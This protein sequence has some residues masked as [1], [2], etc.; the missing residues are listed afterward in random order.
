MAHDDAHRHQS[1]ARRRIGPSR[2]S[3]FIP[4]TRRALACS[5]AGSRASRPR[6]DRACCRSDR[7]TASSPARSSRRSTGA[8]HNASS[9]RVGDLVAPRTDPYSGQPEAKATPAAIAPVDF[10]MRGFALT[11]QPIALPRGHLVG[12]RRGAGWCRHTVCH[13]RSARAPGAIVAPACCRASLPNTSTRPRHLSRCGLR[14]RPARRCVFVGLRACRQSR[15]RLGCGEGAVRSGHDRR[16][17]SARPCSRDAP[18]SPTRGPVVCAASRSA[19]P[20]SRALLHRARPTR[21]RS[22]SRCGPAPTAARACR[23]SE[24]GSCPCRH[25]VMSC[26]EPSDDVSPPRPVAAHGRA[27]A[28]A[29]VLRARR[30]ARGRRRRQAGAAWKVELLSAAGAEVDVYAGAVRGDSRACRAAAARRVQV[31]GRAWAD[32]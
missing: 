8:T 31:H 22:A 24:D 30:Q 13:Q 5:M 9:A 18:A 2:S 17:R 23:S 19:S 16:A 20:R 6:T 10:R 15:S 26:D 32:I 1:E 11:R 7:R 28:A 25:R 12:A 27:G 29:G 4:S 3:R 14:R 21:K